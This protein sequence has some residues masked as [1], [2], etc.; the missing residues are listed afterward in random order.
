MKAHGKGLGINIGGTNHINSYKMQFTRDFHAIGLPEFPPL[1]SHWTV[2]GKNCRAED[3][4]AYAAIP[5]YI[6]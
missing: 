2:T 6:P 5:R 3:R 1:S 4:T